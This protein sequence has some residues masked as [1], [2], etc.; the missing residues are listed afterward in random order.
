MQRN[1]R[2]AYNRLEKLGVQVEG[3]WGERDRFAILPEHKWANYYRREDTAGWVFGVSPI[4]NDIL[5]DCGCWC[6][7]QNPELLLVWEA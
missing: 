4:I 1:L 6:E 3:V 2:K 7:W 5:H